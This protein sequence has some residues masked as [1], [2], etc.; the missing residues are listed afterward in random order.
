M[1][2]IAQAFRYLLKAQ[3]ISPDDGEVRLKIGGIYLRVGK[4][5]EAR[6]ETSF[7]L[8]KEPS[9]LEALA[10]LADTSTTPEEVDD[11]APRGGGPDPRG[12]GKAATSR[13]C[14]RRD[15]NRIHKACGKL[16]DFLPRRWA[17]RPEA[18]QD[19]AE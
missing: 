10:L 12:P 13:S 17:T 15:D 16:D 11:S 6:E 18:S 9:N 3:E 19:P 2:E 14:R 5:A 7:V 1:G 4:P 8:T